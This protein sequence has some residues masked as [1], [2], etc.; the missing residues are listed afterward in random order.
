MSLHFDQV[1][2]PIETS[3]KI[4]YFIGAVGGIAKNSVLA[5][6]KGE[7]R[8]FWM[9]ELSNPTPTSYTK[10]NNAKF[11]PINILIPNLTSQIFYHKHINFHDFSVVLM[12]T[13][14]FFFNNHFP[15]YF[16]NAFC[17][18]SIKNRLI[19]GL[20]RLFAL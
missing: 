20:Y 8:V 5:R 3:N 11:V 12:L 15:R 13:T 7:N 16:L 17:A 9:T 10:H 2:M 19:L 18:I 4:Y 1:L 14:P 6:N